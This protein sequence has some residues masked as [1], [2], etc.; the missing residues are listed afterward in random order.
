ME[1]LK[2]DIEADVESIERS[3]LLGSILPLHDWFC[4]FEV[5]VCEFLFPEIVKTG[6]HFSKL[7]FLKILVCARNKLTESGEDPLVR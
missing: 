3:F 4:G 5:N 6:G 1:E 7:E 2:S